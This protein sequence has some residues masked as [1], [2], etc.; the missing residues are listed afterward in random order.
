MSYHDFIYQEIDLKLNLA[1]FVAKKI[2]KNVNLKKL[3]KKSFKKDEK[4]TITN[5]ND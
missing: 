5:L 1:N 4:K 3:G 2:F